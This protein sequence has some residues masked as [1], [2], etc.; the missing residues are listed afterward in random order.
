MLA[1]RGAAREDVHHAHT[2][3]SPFRLSVFFFCCSFLTRDRKQV[4]SRIISKDLVVVFR[5]LPDLAGSST[6]CPL[7]APGGFAAR[8]SSLE[9]PAPHGLQPRRSPGLQGSVFRCKY[10]LC[11]GGCF[12]LSDGGRRAPRYCRLRGSRTVFVHTQ[13]GVLSVLS[14]VQFECEC[15]IPRATW[16]DLFTRGR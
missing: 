1:R 9:G 7:T 5:V 3:R 6:A 10:E 16:P 13:R 11:T 15:A 8:N 12:R 4:N 14:M 2:L